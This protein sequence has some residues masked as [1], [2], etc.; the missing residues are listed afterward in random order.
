MGKLREGYSEFVKGIKEDKKKLFFVIIIPF[1]LIVCVIAGIIIANNDSQGNSIKKEKISSI[2]GVLNPVDSSKIDKSRKKTSSEIYKESFWDSGKKEEKKIEFF[3][4]DSLVENQK[5]PVVAY[6]KSS[7]NYNYHSPYDDKSSVYHNPSSND[8]KESLKENQTKE[9]QVV[10]DPTDTRRRRAPSDSYGNMAGGKNDIGD[11]FIKGVIANGNRLVKNGSYVSVRLGVE[12]EVDGLTLPR[13]TI[14]TGISSVRKE[15]MEI[16]IKNVR[17]GSKN[18][19]VS[20][21]IYDNDGVKGIKIPESVLN[22]IA[23]DVLDEGLDKGSSIGAN[24]PVVGSIDVNLSK[25]NRQVEFVLNSG[26]KVFIK[27]NK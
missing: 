7:P 23:S 2:D 8:N 6:H 16:T 9:A 24:I 26:H 13:N 5:K 22:N 3:N 18:K 27:S 17:I 4:E 15:R 14:L 19:S 1:V 21:S 11:A 20:W 10:S 25:K 12:T